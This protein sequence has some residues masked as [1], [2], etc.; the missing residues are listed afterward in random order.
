MVQRCFWFA[1]S[2]LRSKVAVPVPPGVTQLNFYSQNKQKCSRFFVVTCNR[3]GSIVP[4]WK[5]YTLLSVT[6][7][8][9]SVLKNAF[10]TGHGG[11]CIS[12]ILALFKI[13]FL[14]IQCSA[15]MYAYMPELGTATLWLLG[16][17]LR[18][19]GRAAGAINH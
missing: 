14:C 3:K 5:Y 16:I 1:D 9:T 17:E 2:L 13:Y 15:C 10:Y 11:W 19:S 12:L 8:S 6:V 7:I 18:T 4:L